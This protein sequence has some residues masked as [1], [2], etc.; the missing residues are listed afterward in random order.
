[1]GDW[2]GGPLL[3]DPGNEEL[4][5]LSSRR[6]SDRY[7]ETDFADPELKDPDPAMKIE[8]FNRTK[9]QNDKLGL[10]D[11]QQQEEESK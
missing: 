5:M 10:P 1:M 8:H 4:D 2:R 3:G 11:N 9:E 6:D 7:V